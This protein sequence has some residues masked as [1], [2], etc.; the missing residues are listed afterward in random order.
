MDPFS[1]YQTKTK[2]NN[3]SELQQSLDSR[4]MLENQFDTTCNV[5]LSQLILEAARVNN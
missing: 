4:K 3:W 1:N 5:T 2:H